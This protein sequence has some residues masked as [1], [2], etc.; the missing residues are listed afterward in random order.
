MAATAPKMSA[1]GLEASVEAALVFWGAP[2]L[3]VGE[4]ELEPEG[5]ADGVAERERVAVETVLLLPGVLREADAEA[6]AEVMVLGVSV[7][8]ADEAAEDSEAEA[9][10]EAEGETLAE[11]PV[12]LMGPM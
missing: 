1:N 4:P 10:A 9:E 2:A 5:R 8:A 6:E 7:V 3:L 11:L 12:S